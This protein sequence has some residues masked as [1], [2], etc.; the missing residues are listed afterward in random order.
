MRIHLADRTLEWSAL[1]CQHY[2]V[3][4]A[5]GVVECTPRRTKVAIYGAGNGKQEAPLDDPEWEVWALNLIPPMDSAGRVRADRWFDLHQR[6]AQTDKDLEWIGKCPM[7]IYVPPD[8]VGASPL[9]VRFPIEKLEETFG[10]A[11]WC[12][13]FSYQ[14]ALAM[15]EGFEEIGLYGVDLAYG[16]MRERTVEWANVSWWMGLAAGSGVRLSVSGQRL[17]QHRGRYGFEYDEEKEATEKYVGFMKSLDEMEA[18]EG[19]GG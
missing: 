14:I 16:T 4:V 15:V 13:T 18:A 8:L 9:C 17:G 6:K 19:M 12:C 10:R 5:T 7:P 1:N 2:A 11:Y 3:D